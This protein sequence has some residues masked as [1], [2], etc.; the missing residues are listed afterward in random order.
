MNTKLAKERQKEGGINWLCPD[1][2]TGQKIIINY[3]SKVNQSGAYLARWIAKSIIAARLA[4]QI[5]VQLYYAIRVVKPLSTHVDSYGT[6]KGF[7][8]TKLVDIIR[9]NFDLRPGVVVDADA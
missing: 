8:N 7:T 2:I 6:S 4:Q 3:W 1:S 5:L 9:C